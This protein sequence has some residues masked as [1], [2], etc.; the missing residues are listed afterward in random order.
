LDCFVLIA[1]KN[2]AKVEKATQ[3]LSGLLTTEAGKDSVMLIYALSTGYMFAKQVPKARN[4]LKRVTKQTW[5]AE[6][7]EYLER[8]WLLLGDIYIQSSKFDLATELI[9]VCIQ[10]SNIIHL[11]PFF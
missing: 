2:K 1:S 10:Y 8:C 7:A 3:E 6:D 9:K 11:L 5:K 4:Q